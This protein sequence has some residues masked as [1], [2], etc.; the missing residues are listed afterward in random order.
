[1]KEF[2]DVFVGL[3]GSMNNVQILHLSNLYGKAMNGNMFHLNKSE[4]GI[5]PW[6]MIPHKQTSYIQHTI[7]EALYNKHLS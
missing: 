7:L 5:K 1:L 4:E 2:W 3:R 6:L